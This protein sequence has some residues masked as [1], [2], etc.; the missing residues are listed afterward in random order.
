MFGRAQDFTF[1]GQLK[2]FDSGKRLGGVK[3]TAYVKGA[4]VFSTTA[5]ANGKYTVKLPINQT[6]EIK[7]SLS[8]FVSK[9]MKIDATGINEE[10]L[11]PGGRIFPPIDIELFADRPNANF[12]F[13]NKEPV[14]IWT[15]HPTKLVMDW[16]KSVYERMK[17][18]IESTLAKAD[19]EAKEGEAQYN[20]LIQE[21]DAA[22][23][24]QDYE[25]ALKKYE[26]AISIKGKEMETHPN[27][28]ILEIEDILQAKRKEALLSQQ[29]DE[30]YNN[31]IAAAENFKKIRITKKRL[32]NSMKQRM[33]SQVK[34]T[35]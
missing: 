24:K 20:K 33:K 3:V 16:D 13:L 22:F 34:I 32:T 30:K 26:A 23:D 1:E 6:Y 10:D 15:Y 5:A 2:D 7:Y 19:K 35:H 27:T 4:E 12:S 11:P 18:K 8:G 31:L 29:A 25:G 21:A 17:D 28:R 9:M 14:V